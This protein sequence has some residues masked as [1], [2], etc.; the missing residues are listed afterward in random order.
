MARAEHGDMDQG[1]QLYLDTA[2]KEKGYTQV[3]LLD[4][5][6]MLTIDQDLSTAPQL[7][8]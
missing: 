3:Q 2:P 5:K 1:K 8:K 7:A 6:T 4:N